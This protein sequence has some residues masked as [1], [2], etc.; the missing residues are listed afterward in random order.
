[1]R[2][3]ERTHH[4]LAR[5]AEAQHGVVS[6]GQ[7]REL[8]YSGSAID[9]AVRSGR[10]HRIHRGV[11]AVGHRRLS[12][13]G[14]CRAALLACGPRALLSHDSSA[15]LWGLEAT[16]SAI[17]EVALRSR[18]HRRRGIQIHYLPRLAAEDVATREGLPTTAVPRTLI[19]RAATI[20]RRSL[21]RDL[22]RVARLGLLDVAAIDH[23]LA[24]AG[25]HPGCAKLRD[26]VELHRDP[27]YTR[28]WLERR[29]LDLV[30]RSGLP[31]PS[32]NVFVAGFELDMYWERE[33]FAV[34]LDGYEFHSGRRSFERDRRRQED[35][36]L[37]G[38]EMVRITARRVMAEPDELMRRLSELLDQRRLELFGKPL[39]PQPWH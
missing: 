15:W 10:F 11:Y 8:G 13:H 4:G 35:L 24:R 39:R 37:A 38:I 17:V 31:M 25:R 16:L 33:R 29:F 14:R 21:D 36:K 3:E 32:A 7:L 2:G 26:A 19:D 23:L 1:M 28:S 22:D 9:R 6:R 20:S 34:E 30:R 18:G 27:A 5:L 12:P